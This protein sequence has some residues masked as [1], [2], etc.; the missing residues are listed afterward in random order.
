[1]WGN[2]AGRIAAQ[3]TDIN[4]AL[5]KI[6]NAVAPR[7]GDDDDEDYEDEDDEYYSDEDEEGNE[8]EYE[9]EEDVGD[10]GIRYSGIVG[11]LTGALD[12]GGGGSKDDAAY[13]Q[14]L[15]R[16]T[17]QQQQQQPVASSSSPPAMTAAPSPLPRADA[18]SSQQVGRIEQNQQ[19]R[20]A[21]S[22]VKQQ[23]T[24]TTKAP[25]VSTKNFPASSPLQKISTPTSSTTPHTANADATNDD[26]DGDWEDSTNNRNDPTNAAPKS[27]DTSKTTP[28]AGG[29]DPAAAKT[30][31]S[32]APA[33]PAPVPLKTQQETTGNAPAQNSATATNSASGLPR[34]ERSAA[35][36]TTTAAAVG[37][38]K[39]QAPVTTTRISSST[40]RSSSA[41]NMTS[42]AV[43][44]RTMTYESTTSSAVNSLGTRP[45]RHRDDQKIQTTTL[46]ASS[47]AVTST[48]TAATITPKAGNTNSS[49]SAET[50]AEAETSRMYTEKIDH[51]RTTSKSDSIPAATHIDPVIPSTKRSTVP[52]TSQT[53]SSSNTTDQKFLEL[54]K[55]CE[56]LQAMV[57]SREK[58]M[59]ALR[60]QTEQEKLKAKKEKDDMLIKFQ[61]KEYRLLQATSEESRVELDQY[62]KLLNDSETRA[63]RSE[64][65]LKVL[66]MKFENELAQ[67]QQR[68]HRATQKS[69]D[70]VA[71]SMAVLDE[72]NDEIAH[73]KK[74][75]RDMESKVNEHQEGA[76][77]AE[78][79]VEELHEE[80]ESLR[81][82]IE[83]LETE[84]EHL[85]SKVGSLEA[86]SDRL[87]ELQI[88]L[89][90]IKEERDRERSKNQSVVDS[91]IT[92]H[93][94]LESERDSALSELQST[95]QQL[96]AALA[97]LDVAKADA[98]RIMKANSNLQS[99]LESFQDERQTEM[100]LLDEQRLESE[101]AINA[102]NATAM[103]ALKQ[104]HERELHEVQKA[105]DEAVRNSMRE[106]AILE[107]NIE[108]LRSENNQMRRSLD[109][110]ISQ[111][112][113]SQE[114]VIDRQVMK[115]MVVDWC[116][117]TDKSK[118]HQVL[119]VLS[120]LLGFSP[121]EKE[122][123]HLSGL[124][125]DSVGSRFVETLAP[126]RTT[127]ADVEHLE[128][129]NVTEKFF[130]FLMEET[131]D[132]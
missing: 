131:N 59:S 114:D 79:E 60:D 6:S 14:T 40:T 129:E 95:K 18:A 11:M 39:L 125:L 96:A 7:E 93:S 122:K 104:T 110:A 10:D 20:P 1:M 81:K 103:A 67:S 21:A 121:E 55:Q 31:E 119:K 90:M 124:D 73:L 116:T 42:P 3:T 71:Q 70:R 35:R 50:V 49:F 66:Q 74:L 53:S 45:S 16:Q 99:A 83:R 19:Q 75:I 15:P 109:E 13:E 107:G 51:A 54:R 37:T 41:N 85:K 84:K 38:P 4:G 57:Q 78:E 2:I 8:D 43:K 9:D 92:S 82:T 76:E 94:Q 89:T 106:M 36:R 97:D 69:D 47:T 22:S 24:T 126:R 48:A 127:T 88:N 105:A 28:P 27:L 5:E 26:W 63:D 44:S 61:E 132:E 91:A 98:S 34:T 68:E 23:T 30:I 102:A 29:Q 46:G 101:E 112:Q 87:A 111:L 52:N 25:S 72:R 12:D 113:S 86:D 123:V 32:P 80:N 117:L 64:Q 128:G 17:Q 33:P 120:N 130:N 65:Q 62:K 56:K 100:A 118:R 115:Q 77:E 108:K 58:E